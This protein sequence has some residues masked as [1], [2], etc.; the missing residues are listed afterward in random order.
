MQ[1]NLSFGAILMYHHIQDDGIDPW[2]T[3]VSESNFREQLQVLAEQYE[4]LP[5][6][7]FETVLS[8]GQK[9]QERKVIFITFDDGYLDNYE[10]AIPELQKHQFPATFYIPTQILK[11]DNYF[12]WEIVDHLFW[13]NEKLPAQI[14]LSTESA[15]LMQNISSAA[16]TRNRPAEINWSANSQ[17]PPTERCKVY[18]GLCSWIKA[19]PV[20]EQQKVVKQ[21][22]GF[23]LQGK[24]PEAEKMSVEMLKKIVSDGFALGGHTVHHPALGLQSYPV[25]QNEIVSCKSEL[26]ELLGKP[27]RSLAYPHGHFN[28]D[29]IKITKEAGYVLACTTEEGTLTQHANP[30]SLPRVWVKNVGGRLFQ[31]HLSRLFK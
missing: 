17:P 6:S 1:G 9:K 30:F 18:L 5:L 10:R 20:E 4:V 16:Q 21:L 31:Q 26:E 15:Q 23:C 28:D 27:V 8:K 3:C 2:E 24:I 22:K 14:D 13:E 11:G 7:D 25:Q 12:W 19:R 29:T